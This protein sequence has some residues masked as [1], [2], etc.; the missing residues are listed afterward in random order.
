MWEHAQD[1]D[2][3][4]RTT[5]YSLPHHLDGHIELIQPTTVFNR[6]KAQRTTHHFMG[7]DTASSQPSGANITIPG[8]GV[9]VDISC[10]STIT[11]S[12]LKQLYNA[13]D[14]TPKASDKNMI[15]ITGYLEQFANFADLQSF[16]ED[17]VPAAVNT[18]FDVVLINGLYFTTSSPSSLIDWLIGRKVVKMTRM[19][20]EARQI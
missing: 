6:A 18:S 10:N 2:V 14:Y 3:L 12:C 13:V 1:G 5:Q 20:L 16:Y 19:Y 9:T 11:V 8:Y 4:V 15:G 17:Q 7:L